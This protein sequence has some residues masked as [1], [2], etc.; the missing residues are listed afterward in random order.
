MAK[1][2]I[3]QL[4]WLLSRA[5]LEAMD[6]DSVFIWGV[7]EGLVKK[8]SVEAIELDEVLVDGAK[9]M[10]TLKNNG[11]PITDLVFHFELHDGVWR[12]DLEK[13]MQS[14]EKAFAD[15][16]QKTKK[17]KVGVAVLLLEKT[18]DCDIPPQIIC[19][20]LK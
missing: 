19:G 13:I 17:D 2:H 3:F 8:D 16:R 4:R 12:L 14:V 5:E 18:H 1:P 10:A 7:D 20:P 15:L 11:Q 9:A 6:G